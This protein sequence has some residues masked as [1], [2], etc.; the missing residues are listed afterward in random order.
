MIANFIFR[1]LKFYDYYDD[2]MGIE[3][4]IVTYKSAF[5]LEKVFCHCK[6]FNWLILHINSNKCFTCNMLCQ[7]SSN[8]ISLNSTIASDIMKVIFH[9][10]NRYCN[11]DMTC[12]LLWFHFSFT[13]AFNSSNLL[14]HWWAIYDNLYLQLIAIKMIELLVFRLITKNF[15]RYCFHQP[16]EKICTTKYHEYQIMMSQKYIIEMLLH[17]RIKCYWMTLQITLHF[18]CYHFISLKETNENIEWRRKLLCISIVIILFHWIRKMINYICFKILSFI[19]L[20]TSKEH[21]NSILDH[22]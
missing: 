9:C 1:V 22:W 21:E 8:V 13:S 10:W 3:I 12:N 15:M 4:C 18:N 7:P 19:G 17:S 16:F 6:A 2:I 14:R 5:S 20:Y 11:L